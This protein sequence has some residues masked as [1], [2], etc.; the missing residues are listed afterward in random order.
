MKCSSNVSNEYFLLFNE[1]TLQNSTTEIC[2]ECANLLLAREKLFSKTKLGK[3]HKQLTS[4]FLKTVFYDEK[5]N[6]SSK[7][8]LW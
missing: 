6:G 4:S 5:A 8:V 1:K 3:F 7:Q 2:T